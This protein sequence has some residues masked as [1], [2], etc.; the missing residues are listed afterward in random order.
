MRG[1]FRLG[2]A[3]SLTVAIAGLACV[4]FLAPHIAQ[5]RGKD[6]PILSHY[7]II[8]PEIAP[9]YGIKGYLEFIY[10]PDS[11]GVLSVDRGGEIDINIL[12]HLV[13]YSPDFTEAG[14]TI[15]PDGRFG[16]G[17]GRYLK[18]GSFVLFNDFVSYNVSGNITIKA[19]ETIPLMMTMR[20]PEDLPKSI[21][22]IQLGGMGIYSL[23]VGIVDYL[24]AKELVIRE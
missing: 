2:I 7:Q 5:V 4:Y 23:D 8:D 15:D 12:F 24:G 20:I 17:S 14:V 19:G 9:Q 6:V 21:S 18:D 22:T 1:K 10:P 3:I 13:S 11:P 16:F